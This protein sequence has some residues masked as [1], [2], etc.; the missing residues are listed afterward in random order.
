MESL[1]SFPQKTLSLMWVHLAM[2]NES[3]DKIYKIY[4]IRYIT[5]K[6]FKL[7][8]QWAHVVH[9]LAT[10]MGVNSAT[11]AWSRSTLETN[12]WECLWNIQIRLIRGGKT[13][14]NC[15][16]H[17]LVGWGPGL[18]RRENLCCV[19]AFNALCLLITST[20]WPATPRLCCLC[21]N[22]NGKWTL[23]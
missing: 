11:A 23:P 10:S 15:G 13:H 1:A 12:L 18:N 6:L 7:I 3:Q 8:L 14:L 20:M 16:Q 5:H 2:W 4:K 21:S 9:A 22:S 19:P 17:H